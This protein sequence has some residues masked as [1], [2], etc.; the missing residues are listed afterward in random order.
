MIFLRKIG[1]CRFSKVSWKVVFGCQERPKSAQKSPKRTHGQKGPGAAQERAK[2][3]QEQPKRTP[4]V[5]QERPRATWGKPRSPP[6]AKEATREAYERLRR[7]P[8]AQRGPGQRG[9]DKRKQE[10]TRQEEKGQE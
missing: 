1:K 2:S 3:R 7:G 10:Q 8:G 9:T 5:P 6:E 4:R